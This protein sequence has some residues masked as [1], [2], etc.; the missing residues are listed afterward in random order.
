MRYHSTI[1]GGT[2]GEP[3]F[4]SGQGLPSA[5]FCVVKLRSCKT[6]AVKVQA[7]FSEIS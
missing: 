4:F 3:L 7:F 1:T 2:A 6:I 5:A